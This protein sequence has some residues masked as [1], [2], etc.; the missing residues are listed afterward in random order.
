[1]NKRCFEEVKLVM[2]LHHK[3]IKVVEFMILLHHGS[4]K[5]GEARVEALP[6]GL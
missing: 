4:S 2:G 3:C 5:G 1:M 6:H